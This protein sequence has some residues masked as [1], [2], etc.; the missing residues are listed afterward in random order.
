MALSAFDDKTRCPE[1]SEVM[2]VLGKAARHWQ[3]II[4]HVRDLYPPIAEE[5][6]FAGAKYGWSLRLKQEKRIVVYLTP[7]SGYFLAGIVL[8]EKAV[9]AAR[10]GGLPAAVLAL[11]ESAPQYA[12]GRG[13]RMEV[14]S[15]GDV[16]AVETLVAAK[17]TT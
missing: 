12:E 11:V 16:R 15:V 13:I 5:W 9:Q 3:Q 8:G 2:R 4:A 14:R 7:Q 6:N 10:D 1:P 17:M